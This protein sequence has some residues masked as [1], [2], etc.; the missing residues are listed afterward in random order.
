M[1]VHGERGGGGIV[2]VPSRPGPLIPLEVGGGP[3][4]PPD[5]LGAIIDELLPDVD[6]A[7]GWA[8]GLLVLGG[9]AV[10][11]WSVAASG[12]GWLFAVGVLAIGLGCVLPARAVWRRAA[13]RRR[14]RAHARVEARGTRLDATGPT[15]ARLV[16]AY[17]ELLRRL[18]D[19]DPDVSGPALAAAHTAV[20]EV[21]TL[22]DGRA[23]SRAE[24]PYVAQRADAIA[25]LARSLA[26]DARRNEAH[27]RAIEHSPAAVVEA[28]DELDALT[29][30]SSVD[31]LIELAERPEHRH[32]DR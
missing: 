19:T 7:P 25:A 21:A 8:D 3:R 32:G 13:G 24:E 12:P 26:D 27:G 17:G 10:A 22:C 2:V 15:T 28:R 11:G 6:D 14:A 16:G 30:T 9:L 5:E 18:P 1:G 23:P 29:G 4:R 31:R 20:L